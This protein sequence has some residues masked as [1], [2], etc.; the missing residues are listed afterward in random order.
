M[1]V[2]F[3]NIC[4]QKNNIIKYNII[5]KAWENFF[6]IDARTCGVITQF[7]STLHLKSRFLLN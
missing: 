3:L 2:F 1:F 4:R 7:R 6:N 5:I